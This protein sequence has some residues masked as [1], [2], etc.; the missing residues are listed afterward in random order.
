LVQTSN[1]NSSKKQVFMKKMLFSGAIVMILAF[2]STDKLIGR[3]ESR[4]SEKET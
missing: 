4:P 1:K 3:W 2:I